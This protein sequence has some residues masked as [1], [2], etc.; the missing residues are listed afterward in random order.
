MVVLLQQYVLMDVV[1]S[2]V[3]LDNETSNF[4]ANTAGISPIMILNLCAGTT[5]F[6]RPIGVTLCVGHVSANTS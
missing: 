1:A 6:R 5:K 4:C 2:H 3:Q